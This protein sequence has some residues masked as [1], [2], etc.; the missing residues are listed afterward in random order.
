MNLAQAEYRVYQYIIKDQ[1]LKEKTSLVTSTLDPVT[2]QAY[3]TPHS[4]TSF[5][6]LRTWMCAGYTGQNKDYCPSPYAKLYPEV[7]Q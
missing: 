6:L 5:E 2:Y 1:T 4:S 3:Q 7:F